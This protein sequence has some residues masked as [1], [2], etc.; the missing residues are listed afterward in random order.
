MRSPPAFSLG[1]ALFALPLLACVQS[2]FAAWPIDGRPLCTESH[3][4]QGPSIV[5]DGAQGAIV[6]WGDGR[7]SLG[8][9][10]AQRVDSTGAVKWSV[11]GVAV[12]SDPG[13]Q[14]TP[15]AVP[16]GGGA[17]VFWQDFRNPSYDIY[18]QRIDPSG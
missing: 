9:I 18:G 8:D 17:V 7:F 2:A 10:Y 3:I 11:D 5:P 6:V 12:C 13:G 15:F 16:I 1:L 4:Q 14:S